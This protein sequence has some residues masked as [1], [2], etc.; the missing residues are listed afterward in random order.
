MTPLSYYLSK[1]I[2]DL[3]I[4]LHNTTEGRQTNEETVIQDLKYQ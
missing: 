2:S 4:E 3:E 1:G